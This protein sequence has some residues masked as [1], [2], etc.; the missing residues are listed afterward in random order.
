MYKGKVYKEFQFHGKYLNYREIILII[1][2]QYL[3]WRQLNYMIKINHPVCILY[4]HSYNMICIVLCTSTLNKYIT[5][6][7]NIDK[8]N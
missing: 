3:I 2:N 1:F 7:I 6:A 5:I 8:K 4:L